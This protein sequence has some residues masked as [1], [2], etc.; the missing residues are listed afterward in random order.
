MERGAFVITPLPCL[1]HLACLLTSFCLHFQFDCA[2]ARLK[3]APNVQ[4]VHPFSQ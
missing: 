3:Q 2:G 1:A 4:P